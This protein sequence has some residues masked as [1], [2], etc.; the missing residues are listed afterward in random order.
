MLRGYE[1]E[2]SELQ[3]AGDIRFASS[4]L[5]EPE[6]DYLSYILTKSDYSNG[7]DLRNKY[8]HGNYPT[9]PAQHGKDYLEFLKIM[10][11]IV[12]KINE[13]FC[14]RDEMFSNPES[15]NDT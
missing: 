1:N 3:S 10:I 5:S 6:Q 8:V 4:L 11:I 7:L 15:L 14:L 13:E 2:I 9:D 12:I